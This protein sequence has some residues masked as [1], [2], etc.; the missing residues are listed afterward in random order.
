M[1]IIDDFL[2]E[3]EHQNLC[4]FIED[5]RFP[6]TYGNILSTSKFN[7]L[8]HCFYQYDEPTTFFQNVEFFRE[9]LDMASLV[10]IKAN[11]NPVTETLQI[12]DDAWHN[13]C[14]NM[15]TAIYYLNTNNGF[16]K[17]KNGDKV[18]SVANRMLIFDSNLKHTGTSCTDAY[19]RVLLNINYFPN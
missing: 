19:A 2:S 11:L 8:T 13:D 4:S 14:N 16:T 9:R 5:N 3:D 1:K 7:Q 12:H 18:D 6:W 17:F 10:R 15:T